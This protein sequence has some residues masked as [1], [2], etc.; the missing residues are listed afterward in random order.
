MKLN[1]KSYP[2]LS[3]IVKAE[4]KPTKADLEEAQATLLEFQR[5]YKEFGYIGEKEDR[6][7]KEEIQKIMDLLKA[8]E[9]LV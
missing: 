1:S 4:M 8:L 7:A 3:N 6:D 9:K 2:T 5:D